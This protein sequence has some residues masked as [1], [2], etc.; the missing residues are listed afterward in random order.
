M[1]LH[2][3]KSLGFSLV[4]MLAEDQLRGSLSVHGE[5]GTAVSVNFGMKE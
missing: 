4:R 5:N 3:A 2:S 1:E